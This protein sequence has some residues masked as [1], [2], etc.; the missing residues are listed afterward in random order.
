MRFKMPWAWF[1]KHAGTL[2]RGVWFFTNK[3][4]LDQTQF[5][6]IDATNHPLIQ[7]NTFQKSCNST[8]A[9][10]K[11]YNFIVTELIHSITLNNALKALN[12]AVVYIKQKYA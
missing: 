6:D 8:D 4:R 2:F 7:F 5:D 3:H 9:K 11:R 12:L 10:L 1:T